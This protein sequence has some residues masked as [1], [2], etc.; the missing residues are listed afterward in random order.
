MARDILSDYGNDSGAPQRSRAGNGGQVPVRGVNNYAPPQGP[1]NI[2]D[3][4]GVGLHGDNMGQ[5]RRPSGG[6]S[7]GKPGIGGENLGCCGTQGKY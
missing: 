5:A 6:Q 3:P 2:T 1:K 7:S 4:A